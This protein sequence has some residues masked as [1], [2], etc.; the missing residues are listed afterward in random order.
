M[1]AAFGAGSHVA[2]LQDALPT[3]RA[4]DDARTQGVSF[5]IAELIESVSGRSSQGISETGIDM[6]GAHA[7]VRAPLAN[8][9]LT[10][11]VVRLHLSIVAIGMSI[12][13][14]TTIDPFEFFTRNC[15]SL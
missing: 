3:I 9:S 14:R 6:H 13:D 5:A 10:G 2:W 4:V 11:Q 7:R 12:P 15:T 1:G 8:S